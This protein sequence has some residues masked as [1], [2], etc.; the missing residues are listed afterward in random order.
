MPRSALPFLLLLLAP[1]CALPTPGAPKPGARVSA[2]P[3]DWPMY[4]YDLLGTRHNKGEKVL[5]TGNVGGLVE[6]W[7]FPAWGTLRVVGAIH[8]TPVVVNGH[9]YFGTATFP[10]VYKLTPD[11]K[12]KWSYQNPD[13]RK[14][15]KAPRYGVPDAGFLNSPLVTND[16][17]YIADVGGFIYALARGDGKERWKIDTRAKPFPGAH[18]SNCLF[19]APV[20]AD[21]KVIVAGGGFEHA[22]ALNPKHR[23]CT[24]RGFVAAL[25]PLTGKVLWKYDVG[26][27]P[28]EFDPP[29]TIEDAWGKHV[30]HCGPSTSSVWSTPSYDATTGL[31][32]FGTDTHNAPRRPTKDDSR[33]YTKHSCA[34]I[35]V[36]VRTGAEKWVTQINPDDV[37]N[38]TMRTWDPK[39]GRYK[40]QSIGDTP[41]PYTI[42][43]GK[44]LVRVVGAGCKNGGFY[45]LDA[46]TG[47]LL[48]HTPVYTGPP[49][50]PPKPR[51]HP[52]TL[53]LPGPMG[54]LQTGCATDGTALYTNGIDSLLVGTSAERKNHLHPPTGGRVVSLSLDTKR[55]NWRHERPKV[56]AVGGTKE[57]P[58]FTNV[59]DPVGSGIALANGVAYFTTTVSNKLVA[60]D[61]ASGKVLK[62]IALPPVWCG[63]SVSRGR[64][65][66]GT[67][68]ILF[69]PFDPKEAYFPKRLTGTLYCFGLPGK[70]EV[71]RLGKGDE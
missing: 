14:G 67:G 66:V 22:V 7:R 47:K 21:G 6:K 38:Y 51:P 56:K 40:D 11:G 31:V 29:V 53:A 1:F 44:E 63:P 27:K 33:L 65:Y 23:C 26:P 5:G 57:K 64:V 69:A 12:V 2:D 48:A 62:E 41:K 9:V 28:E 71:D 61:T 8:A 60:L 70:D 36:D 13:G 42:R 45:V 17:V 20:L 37:W 68:N 18:E 30:F 4:N 54:G 52:R 19:A 43:V 46:R 58:A 15:D 32:Y 35:A 55:E 49:T 24:G 59:G 50:I 34:V 3:G 39:T 10:T 25:E 16:T